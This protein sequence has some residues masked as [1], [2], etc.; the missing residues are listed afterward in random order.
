MPRPVG[1][2][3]RTDTPVWLRVLGFVLLLP[4]VLALLWSYVLP[5]LSTVRNSF[6]RDHLAHGEG[7]MPSVPGEPV[8]V[9]NY[10]RALDAGLV[11]HVA[12]ALLLGL[13]P[14]VTA[15]LAAPLL[16]LVATRA[17]RVARL[18][19]RAVLAL[20][21]AGH[22]PVALYLGWNFHRVDWETFHNHPRTGLVAV[23]AATTFGLVV[24]V[25]ATAFLSALR[26]RTP[27][28]NPGPSPDAGRVPGG[29][30]PADRSP[31]PALLTV[32]GF[33]ALGILAA[34]LQTYTLVDLVGGGRSP[35]A[36][37]PLVDVV[38][39]T[40]SQ[41]FEFGPGSAVSTVLGLL[42]GL[43]G[44]GAAGLLLATRA[45]I[46]FDGWRDAPGTS[47]GHRP[48]P[49]FRVLAVLG[50][51]VLVAA[52]GWVIVPWLTDALPGGPG[53]PGDVD[54]VRTYVD[55]WLPPLPSALVGVGLAALAG[56][57]I[58]ALRPLGRWSELL[59]LPFAPWLFVGIGPLALAYYRR[60]DELE[61]INSFLGLIPPSWLSVPALFAF[62][63]LF[64]GQH[65]RWRS[66]GGFGR[67]L[68][69]PALPMF[70]L[71]VLLTWLVNAQQ[72]LWPLLVATDR[73]AMPAT[74]LV[75]ILAGQRMGATEHLLGLV[76][77]L[78]VML[79]F[80][81][82][83]AALQVGYLDRLAI[84]VGRWT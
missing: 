16:A 47:D 83:F 79:L 30:P 2:P 18:L 31:L 21:V 84:R 3:P 55:T 19:T 78:P 48:A 50:L 75:P 8:G 6:Y 1:P 23:G 34:A 81:L 41:F 14:L 49:V 45:R 64:R 66:G 80:L 20:P 56:F 70:G 62:T 68:V 43:L 44:L 65:R 24:A 33:L 35:D 46:E 11:G 69:L 74:V 59:L 25:A 4:A 58:G 82:A 51:V 57:G 53:L 12:F 61:Q 13:L 26:G 77:P 9:E 40:F 15:L 54:A 73:E 42:L 32:G 63:L 28:P 52:Y 27:V 17:G 7:G 36:L 60:A 39:G 29:A 5:T 71:A 22:T 67:A 10:E 72:R 37:T 76:L 38:H